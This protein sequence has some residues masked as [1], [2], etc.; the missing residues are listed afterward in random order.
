M[1]AECQAARYVRPALVG[2]GISSQAISPWRRGRALLPSQP[3]CSVARFWPALVRHQPSRLSAAVDYTSCLHRA[4][5]ARGSGGFR[6]PRPRPHL[7]YDRRRQRRAWQQFAVFNRLTF[8]LPVVGEGRLLG[9]W[10]GA[11]CWP[12]PGCRRCRS[13]HSPVGRI[14]I[15]RCAVATRGLR[16]VIMADSGSVQCVDNSHSRLSAGIFGRGWAV[17]GTRRSDSEC[18]RMETSRRLP[19]RRIAGQSRDGLIDKRLVRA[20]R[21]RNH[22]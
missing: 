7:S 10:T 18:R 13:R 5:S 19:T 14:A 20:Y 3:G 17:P 22:E 16:C 4:L 15:P 1:I 21:P 11:R 6:E 2:S 12:C 8:L 9:R